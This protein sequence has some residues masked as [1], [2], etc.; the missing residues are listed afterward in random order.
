MRTDKLEKI[1]EEIEG[2]RENSSQT[3]QRQRMIC[4]DM[5]CRI[6]VG[7]NGIPSC[8]FMA[9]DIPKEDISRFNPFTSLR[10]ITVAIA[11]PILQ[12]E[13]FYACVL[14]AASCD[15][16]D[17]F[18]IVASDILQKMHDCSSADNYVEVLKQR[19]EK[20]R[21][22][23]EKAVGQQLS[24]R[25]VIGLWGEINLIHELQNEKIMTAEDL[26]NGPLKSAQDFQGN[27][28]AIEVKTSV[29]NQLE[30]V[31]ISSEI[32]LDDSHFNALFLIAFRIERND[33]NGITLPQLVDMVSCKLADE[34]KKRFYAALL[35]LG[36]DPSHSQLYT[37]GYIL[38]E[39]RNYYVK[40][41]FPRII[42]SDVPHGVCN[43]KYEVSLSTCSEFQ[44]DW[45]RVIA[46]I[47]EYEY[48]QAGGTQ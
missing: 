34:Q 45:D 39:Q 13:N 30:N 29:S 5:P 19:I 20:W 24:D 35:C 6:Y 18:T 8:R 47:K 14:Q 10:G 28:I 26:W 7:V 48:G 21:I 25:M 17:V 23:F 38:K 1:W 31:M 36:Y 32:Q 41:G 40:S 2:Q 11:E 15:Q 27:E 4:I 37:K 33:E 9:F 22:F 46:A 44:V 12:H 16:N 3:I 42:R 43:I